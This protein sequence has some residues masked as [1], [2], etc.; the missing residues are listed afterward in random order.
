MFYFINFLQSKW[1]LRSIAHTG[2]P[3]QE[4]GFPLLTFCRYWKYSLSFYWV[5][6]MFFVQYKKKLQEKS[7][8]IASYENAHIFA[9]AHV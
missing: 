8:S 2:D 9:S 4:Q 3:L 1:Y 5:S 6:S 7:K